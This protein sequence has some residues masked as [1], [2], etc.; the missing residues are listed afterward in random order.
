M[1]R[2][3]GRS[4]ARGRR[5]LARKMMTRTRQIKRDRGGLGA[6]RRAPGPDKPAVCLLVSSSALAQD[7]LAPKDA[8]EPGRRPPARPCDLN[9]RPPATAHR[10]RTN[11]KFSRARG[12]PN[13]LCVA[14]IIQPAASIY[15]EIGDDGG[16]GLRQWLLLGNERARLEKVGISCFL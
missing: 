5:P 16:G 10:S 12:R 13:Q 7:R 14:V 11:L 3:A 1:H 9:A 4:R 8:D 15:I 2:P 6:G